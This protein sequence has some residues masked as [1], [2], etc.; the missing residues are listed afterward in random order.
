M[1][2]EL[3]KHEV[4]FTVCYENGSGTKY[5]HNFSIAVN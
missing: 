2:D 3:S 4:A 5:W 1:L